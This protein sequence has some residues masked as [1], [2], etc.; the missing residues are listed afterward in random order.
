MKELALTRRRVAAR[1]V[2]RRR[3]MD[4]S[5]P[6]LTAIACILLGAARAE[7]AASC[8]GTVDT[9]LLYYDG[10]VNIIASWRGDYTYVCNVH[11]GWGGI[12][13]EVCLGWYGALVK[14]QA[15][16]LNVIA[17]YNTGSYTCSNLPTYA[18]APAPYY[19]GLD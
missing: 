6:I 3:P 15:N 19:L 17:Y 13:A 10:S 5:V 14:A 12:S 9:V 11:G 4:K 8:S 16:S 2:V 1:H 7:A 18:A